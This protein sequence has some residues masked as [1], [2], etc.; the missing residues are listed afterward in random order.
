MRPLVELAGVA[1]GA[2]SGRPLFEGLHVELASER[3]ALIG[4][5]GV[6]KS[7]LLDV[8]AG[9]AEV[10][11]GTV[12]VSSTPHHVPQIL[13]TSSPN[14]SPLSKGELRRAALEEAR[15]SGSEILLLDEP[16]E[17][18][19]EASVAWL[20]GWLSRFR[21]C[22]VVVSHDRRLLQ[23]FSQFFVAS[24]TGCRHLCGTL[25]DVDTELD[26]EYRE[27]E[28]RYAR[29]L[30]RLAAKEAHTERVTRRRDRKKRRG[31]CSELDRATPRIRL[32]NKRGAAQVYQ[33]KLKRLRQERLES[34]REWTKSTRRALAVELPLDLPIPTV[35]G[36]STSP[37]LTLRGV[38]VQ[39]NGRRIVDSMDLSLGRSRIAVVG[40]N[41]AGKTTLLD[42]LMG[43]R[44]ARSGT[45]QGDHSRIGCIEQGC[46]NWM[47][48]ESLGALLGSPEGTRHESLAEILVQHRFPLAL[49]GRPLRSLSPGERTRAALIGLFRR[50]PSPEV[51]VLDEP[52]CGLDLIGQRA[53]TGALRAWPGGL[54]VA[55]HDLGFL[56]EIG[57]DRWIR[58]GE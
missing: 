58:L 46:T 20:R 14:A 13:A 8:L 56:S 41:G 10:R 30:G 17:D 24:E 19:D 48:G 5:N 9:V 4:R 3:V 16:T 18:L 29:N 26:R 45:V 23:D 52:T 38:S 6:G 40:P 32:N 51:L 22:V 28:R 31:R 50:S 44:A 49:A 54:V 1:V 34:L 43:R 33:G 39:A 47:L 55:S 57:V 36:D 7:A 37:V 35:P 2:P 21:G 15:V 11:A 25:A 27:N 42:V 53:L 12:R